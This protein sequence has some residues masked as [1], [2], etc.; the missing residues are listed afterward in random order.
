MPQ[1]MPLFSPH[2]RII[3]SGYE[4]M[5]THH[6]V[7]GSYSW[8]VLLAFSFSSSPPTHVLME[9]QLC[10]GQCSVLRGIMRL[11]K[12][13]SQGGGSTE[14]LHALRGVRG[15]WSAKLWEGYNVH[16]VSAGYGH[17][18]LRFPEV[19][20]SVGSLGSKLLLN[21][22]KLV[23]FGQSL[24]AARCP[25]FDLRT[26]RVRTVLQHKHPSDTANGFPT[27]SST[28]PLLLKEWNNWLKQ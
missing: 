18:R 9:K 24:R 17:G 23:V 27:S 3:L 12:K 10:F 28:C 20:S 16:S 4:A 25:C 14:C 13:L 15:K 11:E 19:L 5:H 7:L 22:Q 2:S 6:S 26:Q 1:L 8:S 21:T